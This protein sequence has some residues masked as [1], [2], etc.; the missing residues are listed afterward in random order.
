VLAYCLELR[1]ALRTYPRARRYLR[2]CAVCGLF[3][4]VDPRSAWREFVCCPYGCRPIWRRR[5]SNKRVATYYEGEAGRKKKR[6]INRRRNRQGASAKPKQRPEPAP[7]RP[8]DEEVSPE[9]ITHLQSV[10]SLFEDRR[11]GRHEIIALLMKIRRQHQ[12]GRRRSSG[13]GAPQTRRTSRGS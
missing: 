8:A 10:L 9:I 13:Y 6:A 4:L 3:F 7:P 12:I 1:A 2:R 11:V 5:L